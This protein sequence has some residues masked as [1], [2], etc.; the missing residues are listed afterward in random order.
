MPSGAVNP[1]AR[2]LVL[3]GGYTGQRFAAAMAQRGAAV[4][5]THRGDTPPSA[6]PAAPLAWLRF[7]PDHGHQLALPVG[8][9]H[10]L[11]TIP[12]DRA[13]RDAALELV[14]ELRQQLLEWVG[15][16]STTGVYGDTRGAWVD[17]T[18]P[19][20]PGLPRSR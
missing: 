2:V 18:S 9:T 8:L 1:R 5:L 15:Y 14:P 16:L 7:D 4:W 10:V 3:G 6:G 19:T 12:P 11:N 13:G 17:E 20:N